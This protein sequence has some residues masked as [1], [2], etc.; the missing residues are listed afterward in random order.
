MELPVGH[1]ARGYVSSAL[2]AAF[3]SFSP[4]RAGWASLSRQVN[5]TTPASNI[6]AGMVTTPTTVRSAF[7]G[8]GRLPAGG[9]SDQE[10][11]HRG[12][13]AGGYLAGEVLANVSGRF[14]PAR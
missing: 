14:S 6:P 5:F 11:L 9:S 13:V 2:P 12:Q 10:L 3:L 7:L 4:K 8:C 1:V